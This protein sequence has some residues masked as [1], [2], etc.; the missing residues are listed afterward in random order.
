M[1][2]KESLEASFEVVA[3]QLAARMTVVQAPSVSETVLTVLVSPDIGTV[4]HKR[5]H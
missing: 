5:G 2:V 1:P 4:I 3:V